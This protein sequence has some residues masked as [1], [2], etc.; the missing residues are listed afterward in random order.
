MFFKKNNNIDYLIVAIGNPEKKYD[1]TRHNI[2]FSAIDY[3]SEKMNIN[4]NKAKFNALYGKGE[5]EGK[6]IILLKPLTYVNLSGNAVGAVCKYFNILPEQVIVLT[7][8]ISLDV[9]R[10]RMRTKGSAGGHNGLKSIIASIGENFIRI[11]IGVGQKPHKDYDLASWVLGKFTDD[12]KQKIEAKFDDILKGLSYIYKED[13]V[14]AMNVIN[15]NR[16]L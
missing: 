10:M 8:D 5:I 16:K 6:K 3:I 12:E 4:I 11:K 15:D 14:S 1:N 2:G 9:G 13:N 7:D